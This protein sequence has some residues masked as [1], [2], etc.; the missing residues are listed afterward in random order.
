MGREKVIRFF[1]DRLIHCFPWLAPLLLPISP[2]CLLALSLSRERAIWRCLDASQRPRRQHRIISRPLSVLTDFISCQESSGRAIVNHARSL[3]LPAVIDR[4]A[5][6]TS[7]PPRLHAP[8]P[9]P[10]LIAV[11]H[12]QNIVGILLRPL[13]AWKQLPRALAPLKMLI[14]LDDRVAQ[15]A[16]ES[17]AFRACHFVAPAHRP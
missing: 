5:I 7:D 13:L 3:R 12:E 1:L 11:S 9:T 6:A 16:E 2:C 15:P 10:P 8:P 17:T 14:S 4:A